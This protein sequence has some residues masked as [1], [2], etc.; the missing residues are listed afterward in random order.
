M[1]AVAHA[2]T[3]VVLMGARRLRSV[4]A[5]LM[6]AGRS[7]ETPA[8]FI[9]EGAGPRQRSVVATLGTLAIE[10]ERSGLGPPAVV[11]V[12]EVVRLGD[13]LQ[14]APLEEAL[15]TPTSR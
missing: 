6:A 3:V 7:A 10:V 9:S 5:E 14:G 2:D 12:G 8:A 13:R 4:A 1:A 11:V 15:G